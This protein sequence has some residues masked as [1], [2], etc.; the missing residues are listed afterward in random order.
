MLFIANNQIVLLHVGMMLA[1]EKMNITELFS[2]N[3]FSLLFRS[4]WEVQWRTSSLKIRIWQVDF[5]HILFSK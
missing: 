2:Q 4:D 5:G 3:I 1:H